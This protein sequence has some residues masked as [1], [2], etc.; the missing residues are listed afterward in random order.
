MTHRQPKLLLFDIDGTLILSGG[1]GGAALNRACEEILGVQNAM[2]AVNPGGMTDGAI[3]RRIITTVL[4]RP[5]EDGEI[6]CILRRYLEHLPRSLDGSTRFRLLPGFPRLLDALGERPDIVLGLGTGNLAE[7]AR[8]KLE[9]AGLFHY[10]RFG[11]FGSDAEDRAELLRRGIERGKALS[12][13]PVAPEHIFVIG[14]TPHDV[15][16]GRRAGARTVAVATGSTSRQELARHQPD[17]LFD[18]FADAKPFMEL[19]A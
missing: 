10:F 1:A 7:G 13:Q 16:S 12:P 19:M 2:A 15:E 5:P 3:V 11:G 18:S 6:E 8:I 4:G 17:Y 14:D 9:F